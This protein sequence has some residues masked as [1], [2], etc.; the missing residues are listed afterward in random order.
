M[1]RFLFAVVYTV[2]LLGANTAHADP[3]LAALLEGDMRKLVLHADPRPASDV[4]F[5]DPQGAEHRLADWRGRHLVVN[6]W[7]TWC[8]PCRKEMPALDALQARYGGGRFAVLTIA[9]GR[10]TLPGIDKFFTEAGVKNLPVLLD[11][12]SALARDSGVFG[13]PVTLILDPEGREIGRMVG[14][15]D[16]AGASA[17]AL[18]EA[19]LAR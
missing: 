2:G 1:L 3:A 19:L 14:E 5:T 8:A 18:V 11:A 9:T 15:A 16:W 7:A 6:F 12:K 13:L 4:A 10:N 17:V